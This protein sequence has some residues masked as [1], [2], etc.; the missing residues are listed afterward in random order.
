[1]SDLLDAKTNAKHE[2][3]LFLI[4]KFLK[5][6][7]SSYSREV[8]I[9]KKI[10]K[11]APEVLEIDLEFKLNSLAWF[12]TRPGIERINKHNFQNKKVDNNTNTEYLPPQRESVKLTTQKQ[13]SLEEFLN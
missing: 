10:I 9:A 7:P 6:K 5:E 12:L 4:K 2:A 13:T 8:A 1:M 3:A 11:N